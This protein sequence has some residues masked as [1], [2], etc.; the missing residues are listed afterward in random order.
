MTAKQ[1]IAALRAMVE[2][3]ERRLEALERRALFSTPLG[4]DPS[5][6]QPYRVPTSPT[7]TDPTLARDIRAA[8]GS[9][10]GL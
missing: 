10:A 2:T 7:A 8:I 5:Y 6:L 9:G 3:L 1:E 4:P